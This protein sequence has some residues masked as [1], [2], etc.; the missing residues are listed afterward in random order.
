MRIGREWPVNTVRARNAGVARPGL[1]ARIPAMP[2]GF[3]RQR[4]S[5]KAVGEASKPI[6]LA[7]ELP[8]PRRPSR[9][10]RWIHAHRLEGRSHFISCSQV[11]FRSFRNPW[12]SLDRRCTIL[13][14]QQPRRAAFL[15]SPVIG[16]ADQANL[17]FAFC[18]VWPPAPGPPTLS[19]TRSTRDGTR[20][21]E[22]TATRRLAR[23]GPTD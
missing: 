9:D 6:E 1:A 14:L 17:P 7:R 12:P 23:A 13:A 20:C 8:A 2:P 16:F 11:A 18:Q 10:S 15:N 22:S 4:Q 19:S 5:V 3:R 21:R